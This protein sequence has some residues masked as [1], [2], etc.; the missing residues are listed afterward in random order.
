MNEHKCGFVYCF[1]NDTVFV[2]ELQMWRCPDHRKSD[3]VE[4]PTPVVTSDDVERA[5]QWG[6]N[7]AIDAVF[8]ACEA[9][10][11]V[12]SRKASAYEWGTDGHEKNEDAAKAWRQASM[13]ASFCMDRIRA[14]KR[15]A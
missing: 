5:A 11:D 14:L 12:A 3:G 1:R 2:G 7:E 8:K 9:R 10:H 13:E 15:P 4:R 6:W